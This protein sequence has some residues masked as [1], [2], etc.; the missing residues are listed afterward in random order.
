MSG[1]ILP[2]RGTFPTVAAD[3]F[4]AEN[5][6][7][8]GAVEVGS[9]ANIWYGAVLRGDLAP[10]HV[11]AF[12]NVQD[13]TVVHVSS[14][15]GGAWIGD[16]V[17]IGHLALIHACRLEDYSFIGMKACV[18]DEAVVESGAWVAA[19]A[20]VT[21]GK[22]VKSGEL[23]AGMPA[24]PVRQV[25]AEERHTIETLPLRYAELADEHRR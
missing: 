13:G 18:M 25:T 16:Y 10:I 9:R 19:G 14:R 17:T 22:R 8:I 15:R 20:V 4:V 5:A 7:L 23:W 1:L 21:P 11:G 2:F 6:T 3:A 12:A 24:R